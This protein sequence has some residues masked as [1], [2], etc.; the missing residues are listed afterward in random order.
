MPP[1]DPSAASAAA[2]ADYD[3]LG[4]VDVLTRALQGIG[5]KRQRCSLR[6]IHKDS[7]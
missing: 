2:R 1:A 4:L 7:R 5:A 3:D 6:F